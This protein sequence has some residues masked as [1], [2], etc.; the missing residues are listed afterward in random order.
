MELEIE[1]LK[2][3]NFRRRIVLERWVE[4]LDV[5]KKMNEKFVNKY[6]RRNRFWVKNSDY[7]L[8]YCIVEN[9][10]SALFNRVIAEKKIKT[11]AIGYNVD[12]ENFA[13]IDVLYAVNF[14]LGF[15]PNVRVEVKTVEDSIE[16]L[17]RY[18]EKFKEC[19]LDY[20]ERRQY[21]IKYYTSEDWKMM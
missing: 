14:A 16:L 9:L 18:K 13:F 21:W 1:R 2:V 15:L 5:F 6:F 4:M 8:E 17:N 11:V 20:C 19:K 3:K 12:E 7:L 10:C